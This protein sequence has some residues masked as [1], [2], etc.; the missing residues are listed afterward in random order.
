MQ[1]RQW[2]VWGLPKD[3]LSTDNA[4]ALHA[5]VGGIPQKLCVS[6]IQY[7]WYIPINWPSIRPHHHM[8]MCVL[9]LWLPSHMQ[10]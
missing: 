2:Q 1:I 3:Q 5:G 4:I 9:E 8:H 7:Y 6:Y 10:I